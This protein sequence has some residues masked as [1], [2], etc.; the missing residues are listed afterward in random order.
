MRQ[1]FSKTL[2]KILPQIDSAFVNQKHDAGE[3][4]QVSLGSSPMWKN[5]FLV[6]CGRTR[7]GLQPTKL[8]GLL[9]DI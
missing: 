6:T 4:Y 1:N 9:G 5:D 8:S 2:P 7:R 3:M